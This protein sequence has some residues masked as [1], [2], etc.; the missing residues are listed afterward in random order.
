MAEKVLENK[1]ES[2]ETIESGPNLDRVKSHGPY[3]KCTPW[4][5]LSYRI[6]VGFICQVC[7]KHEDLVG[8]LEIHRMK[9]G[10]EGGTYVPNNSKVCCNK[11][12]EILNSAQR[13][14]SGTQSR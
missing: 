12:H 6:A 1:Y 8:E 13:I 9:P 11:C 10:N 5:R 2:I 4:L 14:A 3:K 7:H